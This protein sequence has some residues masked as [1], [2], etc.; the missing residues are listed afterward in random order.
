MERDGKTG[1]GIQWNLFLDAVLPTLREQV[2]KIASGCFAN[3]SEHEGNPEV[4]DIH[5]DSLTS[6]YLVVW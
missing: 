5:G 2:L 3:A 4:G 6:S 1:A